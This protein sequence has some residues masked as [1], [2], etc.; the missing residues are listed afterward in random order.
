MKRTDDTCNIVSRRYH[1]EEAAMLKLLTC[2]DFF[3]DKIRRNIGNNRNLTYEKVDEFFKRNQII[4]EDLNRLN[5]DMAQILDEPY[6]P[7]RGYR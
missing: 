3:I 1:P 4:M 5:A 2:R 6:T 7:P